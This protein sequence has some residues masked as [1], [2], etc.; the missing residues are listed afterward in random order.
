MGGFPSIRHNEVRD[1]TASLLTEICHNVSVEP[2]L[3]PLSGELL[4]LRTANST[5]NARLDI[6]CDGFWGGR[7]ERAFFDIRVFNPCAQ[8]NKSSSL[9]A[10]YRRH[11]LEKRRSYD[12]RIREVEHG[13]F[14]P[15]VFSTTGGMGKAATVF[16]KRL[17][18]L[19]S[20]KLDEDTTLLS[21]GFGAV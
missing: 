14:T 17:A 10:T 19:L 13:T 9:T 2:H 4:S 7:F 12:Q 6:A 3:Q 15:L 1:V 11:E 20:D 18:S 8:S 16:Y 5:D 21:I